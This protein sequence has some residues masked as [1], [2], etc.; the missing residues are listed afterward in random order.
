MQWGEAYA[1]AEA[2]NITVVGGKNISFH[3]LQLEMASESNIGSDQTV[4]VSGGWLQVSSICRFLALPDL[5]VWDFERVVDTARY[6]IL[7]GWALTE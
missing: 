1:F 3:L 7:W 5:I 2:H 6:P 4:G